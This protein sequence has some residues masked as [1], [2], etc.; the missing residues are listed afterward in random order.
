VFQNRDLASQLQQ[1]D[2][3]PTQFSGGIMSMVPSF[4]TAGLN[5]AEEKA[6]DF[7]LSD[8]AS[9]NFDPIYDSQGRI[10]GSRDPVTGAVRSGMDF[11]APL[12]L[13]DD[14]DEPV[15]KPL[16]LKKEEE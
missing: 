1:L 8:L 13:G 5:F 15:I 16:V 11:N 12:D 4:L 10:T 7:I 6:K 9:G 3:R 2:K 14:S